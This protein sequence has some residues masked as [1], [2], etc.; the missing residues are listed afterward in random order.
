MSESHEVRKDR[1]AMRVIAY[2]A[3]I[4]RGCAVIGEYPSLKEAKADIGRRLSDARLVSLIM[5]Y[6]NGAYVRWEDY[7]KA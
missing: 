7:L 6:A 4:P 3:D 2:D 5:K 1:Q